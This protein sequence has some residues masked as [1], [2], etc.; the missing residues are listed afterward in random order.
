MVFAPPVARMSVAEYVAF[1]EKADIR[2]ELRGDEVLAMPQGTPEH[3]G[4]AANVTA[5]LHA[6]V[7]GRRCRVYSSDMRVRIGATRLTTYPDVTVVCGE[8]EVDAE[9]RLA[10][11]NPVV[12]VEVLSDSTSSD[13]RGAKAAH[14]RRLPSLME[15]VLVA[16][17]E[18]RIEVHRRVEDRWEIHD[19]RPGEKLPLVS[20]GAELDVAAVY[21]DP[22]A[23]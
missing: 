20:I 5:L 22:L 4:L 11:I 13:D 9:D 16:Q 2:H 15:Y 6:G 10:A 1:E 14:Y 8:L 19:A 23:S 17:D 21:R 18:Q 7:R 3:A 12:I